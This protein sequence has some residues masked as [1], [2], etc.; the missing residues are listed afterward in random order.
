MAFNM[1]LGDAP[2]TKV[3]AFPDHQFEHRFYLV[4]EQEKETGKVWYSGQKFDW[5]TELIPPDP[6]TD[7]WAFVKDINSLIEDACFFREKEIP[8]LQ[9]KEESLAKKVEDL[10]FHLEVRKK[11]LGTALN[12]NIRNRSAYY[13]LRDYEARFTLLHGLAQLAQVQAQ[14]ID[15]LTACVVRRIQA[16][17]H[18]LLP[19]FCKVG[20][21]KPEGPIDKLNEM[22]D[23]QPYF[24]LYVWHP[25]TDDKGNILEEYL[26]TD[27]MRDYPIILQQMMDPQK[28]RALVIKKQQEAKSKAEARARGEDGKIIVADDSDVR[29]MAEFKKKF[30]DGGLGKK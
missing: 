18:W 19:L 20:M 15:L 25:F 1:R 3:D 11:E 9:A 30:G 29:S 10:G 16:R 22:V 12:R 2:P 24:E 27:A 23:E 13:T 6:D 28:Y 8:R 4:D 14:V 5:K 21:R 26:D 7:W 17:L